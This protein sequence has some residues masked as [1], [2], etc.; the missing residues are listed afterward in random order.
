MNVFAT[1]KNMVF[2]EVGLPDDKFLNYWRASTEYTPDVARLQTREKWWLFVYGE[3]M[4]RHAKNVELLGLCEPMCGANTL[5]NFSM[6]NVLQGADSYP[7]ALEKKLEVEEQP[8]FKTRHELPWTKIRGELYLVPPQMLFRLDNYK[9]NG[10]VWERKRA[11]IIIPSRS[12]RFM[13]IPKRDDIKAWMYTGKTDY[14]ADMINDGVQYNNM[15]KPVRNFYNKNLGHSY[16]YYT[17]AECGPP[18]SK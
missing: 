6:W 11:H 18:T 13:G 1:L 16:Y 5:E 14:W 3:E 9:R 15:F 8:W 12:Q 7:I 2:K 17:L 10:V 4:M